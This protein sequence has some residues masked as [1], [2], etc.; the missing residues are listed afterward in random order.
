VPLVALLQNFPQRGSVVSRSVVVYALQVMALP[1]EGRV[2]VHN[3]PRH[4]AFPR[5]SWKLPGPLFPKDDDLC[6]DVGT[7]WALPG[8]RETTETRELTAG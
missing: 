5:P 1:T 7:A 2:S 4:A 8:V 6:L 3:H